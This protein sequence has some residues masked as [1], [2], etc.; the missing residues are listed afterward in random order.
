MATTFQNSAM[1]LSI[2]IF[3]TLMVLGLAS[4]LPATLDHGLRAHGVPGADAAR[5]SHLPPVGLLFASFL[6]YNP[7]HTLL[8]SSLTSLSPHQAAYL[9]GRQFFPQLISQPFANGLR[10][11]FDFAIVTC[12]LAAAASWFRGGKYVHAAEPE[13]AVES[14]EGEQAIAAAGD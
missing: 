11:A 2:G 4:T 13:R 1:V 3:F 5:V 14:A 7:M 6:G 10:A 9:T 12:L 8:G